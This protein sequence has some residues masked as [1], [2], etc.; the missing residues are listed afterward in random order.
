MSSQPL[1]D[2]QHLRTSCTKVGHDSHP[3]NQVFHLFRDH[4]I[5]L[6]T[7]CPRNG[8]NSQWSWWIERR[9]QLQRDASAGPR[10]PVPLSQDANRTTWRGSIAPDGAVIQFAAASGVTTAL[11]SIRKVRGA[12][13]KTADAAPA[14]AQIHWY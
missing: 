5:E 1:A 14:E 11:E 8:D 4:P 10:L 12:T 9:W 2:A 3:F 13:R 7:M 6:S